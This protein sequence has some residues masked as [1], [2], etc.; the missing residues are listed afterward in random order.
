[1]ETYSL[2]LDT[3]SQWKITLLKHKHS[4]ETKIYLQ[5]PGSNLQIINRYV[6]QFGYPRCRISIRKLP[7]SSTETPRV[8]CVHDIPIAPSHESLVSAWPVEIQL[9]WDPNGLLLTKVSLFFFGWS[10]S[11]CP[12]ST[13]RAKVWENFQ[14]SSL[15]THGLKWSE[16]WVLTPFAQIMIH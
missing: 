14:F 3:S 6:Q 15:W 16:W 2:G 8:T 9:R 13:A 5:A 10:K 12:T 4:A 7:L 1:M 11:K